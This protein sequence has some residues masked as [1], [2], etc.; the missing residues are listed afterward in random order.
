METIE[1]FF[2]RAIVNGKQNY[3]AFKKNKPYLLL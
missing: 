1:K 2:N 3:N